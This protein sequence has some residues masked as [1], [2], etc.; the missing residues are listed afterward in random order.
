MFMYRVILNY[1]GVSMAYKFQMENNKIKLLM[2]YESAT[3]KVLLSVESILQ[4][5]KRLQR[6]HISCHVSSFIRKL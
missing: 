5:A 6:A 1:V 3:Q 4:N 2:E